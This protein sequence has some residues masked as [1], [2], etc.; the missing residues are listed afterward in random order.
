MTADQ[1]VELLPAEQGVESSW[2]E[3]EVEVDVKVKRHQ[4]GPDEVD[5]N[6]RKLN[7]GQEESPLEAA[8]I[9]DE[10]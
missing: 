7:G 1:G 3:V 6:D 10:L 2:W 5:T 8:A 9:Q 4:A